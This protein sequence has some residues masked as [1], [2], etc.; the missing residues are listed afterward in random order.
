MSTAVLRLLGCAAMHLSWAMSVVRFHRSMFKMAMLLPI[1]LVISANARA[2]APT[3]APM[4]QAQQEVVKVMRQMYAAL[5]KD[6]LASFQTQVTPDYYAF[7]VGKRFTAESLVAL[8]KMLHTQGMK[9][10]W[11]VTDPEVHVACNHAWVTYTN[12]GSIE[13]ADGKKPAEWLESALL[14]YREGAWRIRFFHST[15]VPRPQF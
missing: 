11:T 9:F 5:Q 2:D 7:D 13:I 3:C 12:L 10:E 15:P 14:E 4:P 8:I 6:D 1:C